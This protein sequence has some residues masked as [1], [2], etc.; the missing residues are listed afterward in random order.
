MILVDAVMFFNEVELLQARCAEHYEHVDKIIVIEA[1]RTHSN[2]PKDLV[3]ADSR[4]KFVEWEDKI[5]HV[6]V[7][8][9]AF[10]STEWPTPQHTALE[11]EKT[12]RFWPLNHG[13]ECDWYMCADADE[14]IR[15]EEFPELKELLAS[16]EINDRDAVHIKLDFFYYGLNYRFDELW[17]ATR[18]RRP[19]LRPK[20]W[21]RA[22]KYR[23]SIGWHFSCLGG[24]EAIVRKLKAIQH[25][26]EGRVTSLI[27]H[28]ERIAY[29]V[30]KRLD[31]FNRTDMGDLNVTPDRSHLP[32]Y[33][34][35]HWDDFEQFWLEE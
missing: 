19:V 17:H 20:A 2:E 24:T 4:S 35:D 27:E 23:K 33:M 21:F 16:D 15:S 11:N 25:H 10:I 18:F 7:P 30:N 28:P 8:A 34:L 12:Q 3:F 22:Y 31:L 13:L 14:I 29:Q 1:E 32:Q 6:I 26:R 5:E 9:D